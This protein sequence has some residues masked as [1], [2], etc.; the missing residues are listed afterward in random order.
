MGGLVILLGAGLQ[1][2]VRWVLGDI[3]ALLLLLERRT[4]PGLRFQ[5]DLADAVQRLSSSASRP[6]A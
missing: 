4:R 5:L 6:A 1:A 2:F 3:L